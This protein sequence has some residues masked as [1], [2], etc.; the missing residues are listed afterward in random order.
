MWSKRLLQT[1][2]LAGLFFL[3]ACS[4]DSGSGPKP[5]KWDR[6]ACERCRMLVS[7][8]FH[9]AQVRYF[10]SE[11]KRS[12]VALFDD[13]GCATL[14]LADK[15]WADDPKTGIWVA[16]HRT[17]EWIDAAGATYVKGNLTPMEYG[18]GAQAETT[19][20]GLTF[21]QAKRHITE[22]EMRFNAHG[23][24]QSEPLKQQAEHRETEQQ[25]PPTH[26]HNRPGFE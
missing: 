4:G 21:D 23:A 8:R 7:D 1:F 22:V 20:G 11:K 19:S 13:I 18:L 25:T 3:A 2:S 16:D 15:P 9:A 14:W 10:P 6:D 26:T 5:I 24:H 17:G 12:V